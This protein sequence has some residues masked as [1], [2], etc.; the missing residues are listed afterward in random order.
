[1]TPEVSVVV[2]CFNYGRF[3]AGCLSSIQTQT[4]QNFEVI[5]VDDGST[6]NS[7][8]Q[9]VPF[10]KDKRFKYI[11]QHN[12]GQANAKNRGI[13]ET[14]GKYI[15]F[16]DA[17]DLWENNK[18]E[19]QLDL[20]KNP[21][22]GVVYSLAR[23]INESGEEQEFNFLGEYTRPQSRKVSRWLILDNFVWFSS[24]VVRRKCL[25]EFGCFDETLKMGIDWD[26]WLKISTKYE[27]D[28]VEEPLIA[29]RVGHSGQMSKN[30]ETRQ[31]CSDLIM[32]RFLNNYPESVEKKT[33]SEAYYNTYCNRGNFF[34]NLDK[35]KSYKFYIK[36]IIMKPFKRNA[37][38]GLVKNLIN[39]KSD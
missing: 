34:R 35:Q 28:Y 10:L 7:E 26:L 13:Q 24:A 25:D 33:I 5:V 27:F 1:M 16:L 17:D 32:E 8:E 39:Y 29:Y 21:V 6:D 3:V 18:L 31:K 15:A 11:K 9:I 38:K 20:F 14:T 36:A 12:G 2:T 4:F 23:L 37:Y 19:K 30:V 22:V